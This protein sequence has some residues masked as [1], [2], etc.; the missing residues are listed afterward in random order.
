M[1]QQKPVKETLFLIKE[2]NFDSH[3]VALSHLLTIHDVRLRGEWGCNEDSVDV[4][5]C[6]RRCRKHVRRLQE[7]TFITRATLDH[8]RRKLINVRRSSSCC[9][10]VPPANPPLTT[11]RH[12]NVLFLLG[13]P[14]SAV[15]K[16]ID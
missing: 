7:Q 1:C 12:A 4:G 5:L 9:S 15:L 6:P 16:R 11:R 14:F 3:N 13:S 8:E 10:R 2:R